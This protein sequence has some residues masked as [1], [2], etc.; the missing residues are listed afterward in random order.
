MALTGTLEK[1]TEK[2]DVKL[3][4]YG[5]NVK[6]PSLIQI[7]FFVLGLLFLGIY[8]GKSL[9]SNKE[10]SSSDEIKIVKETTYK[11]VVPKK[12]DTLEIKKNR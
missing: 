10:V 11:F 9:Y 6:R 7:T 5:P 2:D 4:I 3:S 12:I 1:C 8:G